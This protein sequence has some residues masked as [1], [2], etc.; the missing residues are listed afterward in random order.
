MS[1]VMSTIVL[2]FTILIIRTGL[3][4]GSTQCCVTAL[5][6][7]VYFPPECLYDHQYICEQKAF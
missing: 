2:L 6:G 4:F 7:I 5:G 3:A 1:R